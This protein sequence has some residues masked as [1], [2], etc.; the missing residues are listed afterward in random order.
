M[1]PSDDAIARMRFE[2]GRKSVLLAYLVWF[3]LGYGGVHRMYLGKWASGVLMLLLFGLSWLL[4]PILIG[5]PIFAVIAIWWLFDALFI[6]GMARR[7]DE[8]LIETLRY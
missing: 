4:M 6:P 8:R 3:F 1:P 5:W 2:A 7:A